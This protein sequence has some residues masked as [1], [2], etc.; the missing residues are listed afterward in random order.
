MLHHVPKSA[1]GLTCYNVD[2]SLHEQIIIIFGR[3]VIYKVNNQTLHFPTSL[4]QCFWTGK[5]E[6]PELLHIF[7]SMLHAR[8]ANKHTKHT[9]ICFSYAILQC[10]NDRLYA[11]GR[12][13]CTSVRAVYSTYHLIDV[14]QVCHCVKMGVVFNKPGVKTQ[15][16]VLLE[17][18]TFSTNVTHY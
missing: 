7:T 15:N 13:F 17:R 11:A 18:L 3:N 8:F 16:T 12:T 1:T 6:K 5:T 4:N 14:Y 10:H 2:I 9:I